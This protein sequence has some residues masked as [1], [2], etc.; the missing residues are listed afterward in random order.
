VAHTHQSR[1][2][3]LPVA[4][5]L[6]GLVAGGFVVAF[7]TGALRFGPRGQAL[8]VQRDRGVEGLFPGRE[9]VYAYRF[10]GGLPKCWAHVERPSGPETL[11]LDAKPAAV[12]GPAPRSPPDEI[13]GLVALVGPA[14][15]EKGE[16]TLH[17]VV[18]KLGFLEGRRPL[19]TATNATYWTGP[20]PG[21]PKPPEPVGSAHAPLTY[22]Q[23]PNLKPGQEIELVNGAP[24]ARGADGVRVRMWLQFYTSDELTTAEPQSAGGE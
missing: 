9:A 5:G 17:L 15:G 13:E 20:N 23:S 3:F 19:G 16:Y 10:R 4:A 7:A 8:E 18:T 21:A 1:R 12:Q 2:I 14:A 22:R 11:S 6:V 24:R